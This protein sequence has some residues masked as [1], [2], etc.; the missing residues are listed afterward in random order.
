MEATVILKVL[1]SLLIVVGM[2]FVFSYLLKNYIPKIGYGGKEE[3]IKIRDIK[4]I[5]RDKGVATFE[6]DGKIFLIAFD[7]TKISL[8]DKKNK[9][10]EE[11]G[12]AD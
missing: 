11:N 7:N 10:R 1:F 9:Q 4:F 2:L 5:S 12:P 6:F 3:D 8:L